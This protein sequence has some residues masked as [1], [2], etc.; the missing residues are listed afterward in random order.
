MMAHDDPTWK[1]LGTSVQLQKTSQLLIKGINLDQVLNSLGDYPGIGPW[2]GSREQFRVMVASQDAGNVFGGQKRRLG[3]F[4]FAC[5]VVDFQHQTKQLVSDMQN[6]GTVDTVFHVCTGMAGGTGSGS[7][8]DVI[9]QLRQI[10]QD[11]TRYRIIVYGAMP[12]LDPSAKKDTTGNYHANAYAALLELNALAVGAYQPW[13]TSCEVNGRLSVRDPFNCCYIFSDENE[14]GNRVN[15]DEEF[16]QH[17]SVVPIPEDCGGEGFHLGFI[18]AAGRL[19]K[20]GARQRAGMFP[21]H[22]EALAQLLAGFSFG[23]KQIA[24]PEQEIR[25]LLTYEFAPAGRPAT[26]VQ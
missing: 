16:T 12:E 15:Y 26:A 1:I 19:R 21:G 6:G 22:S 4:L 14:A 9:C 8:I 2:L 20:Y 18:E 23:V 24:Y 17:R 7:V 5:K 13:D 10:Y 11:G 25:E 3:R